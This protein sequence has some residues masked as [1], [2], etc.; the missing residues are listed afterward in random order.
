MAGLD[1]TPKPDPTP[2]VLYTK[3][4]IDNEFVDA[5]GGKTFPTINPSTGTKIIDISEASPADVDKAVAAAKRAFARGSPW[6]LTSG[7][8]RA[9]MMHKLADL[10]VQHQDEI[11]SLESLDNG[12]PFANAYGEVLNA[13]ELIR[14]YAG[15]ADKVH[16]LTVPSDDGSFCLTRKEPI[17]V[18]GQITPWNYPMVMVALKL[19]P[20]LAAGCTCV[21]KP[22]EQTSLTAL[23]VA[24]F[25]KEAGFPPG[26]INFVPGFGQTGAALT[27]HKDVAK[28]S[29]TGSTEVGHL[30]LKAAGES[31]LKRVTLELGGKSPLVIFN[32][33]DLDLAAQHA[34]EGLFHN[35]GQTCCAPTRV[36]VQSKVY[37]EFVK[38]AVALALEKKVGDPFVPGVNQGPQI[39]TETFDKILGLIESGKKEGAKLETGGKRLGKAGYFVE[40]TV[41]SNVTDNMQ[42]AKE[43]IFGPVQ[44]IFKFETLEEVIERSNDTHYG[45]AAGVFTKNIDLALEYAKAVEAGSVWINQWSSINFQTPFGGFKESGIG[46]EMGEESMNHYFETKSISIRLPTRS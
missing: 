11:A 22:A 16:G 15:W 10:I 9:A 30:I 2:K 3:L 24:S 6:R 27:A 45:L 33:A 43:E 37:D 8:Q 7:A 5:E 18:V 40:P 39:D 19:A 42:I 29:F 26:V 44:S 41:F 46:R 31:N 17:G 12:K 28:I 35:A 20:A 21:F 38:K 23:R 4:F 13:A 32:D 36:F 14:Y 1:S 34:H 25:V